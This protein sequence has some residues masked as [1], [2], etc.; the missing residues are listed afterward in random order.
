MEERLPSAAGVGPTPA[1]VENTNFGM[2]IAGLGLLRSTESNYLSR[3]FRQVE[4]EK[5]EEEE[6][7]RPYGE[8][9]DLTEELEGQILGTIE[10]PATTTRGFQQHADSHC[11]HDSFFMMFFESYATKPIVIGLLKE[12]F[13]SMKALGITNL[14]IEKPIVKLLA[15]RLKEIRASTL[16]LSTWAFLVTALQRYVLLS[17]L[18]LQE[19][20]IEVGS[21]APVVKS[22]MLNRRKS[23]RA[24]K[25]DALQ[26]LLKY[27]LYNEC[28]PGLGKRDI[29]VFMNSMA[30]F[31]KEVSGGAYTLEP[32]INEIRNPASVR[33]YYFSIQQHDEKRTRELLQNDYMISRI[34]MR[35]IPTEQLYD[36]IGP[37]H[38]ISLFQVGATWFLYDN[39]V[40]I[41][42]LAEA[43]STAVSAVGIRDMEI[44]ATRND[45]IY[46]IHLSD[47]ADFRVSQPRISENIEEGVEKP[48]RALTI[49]SASYR[50]VEVE[51]VG[52]ARRKHA[53]K[54]TRKARR[55]RNGFKK[56]KPSRRLREFL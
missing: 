53:H 49:R 21:G 44:L 35:Y 18:F 24:T 14:L 6:R 3:K 13:A 51:R 36:F 26:D 34:N 2:K 55:Q 4:R 38:I 8:S 46:R 22:R 7:N 5:A 25:F 16:P 23:I 54:N 41:Y 39:E 11:W 29:Q 33:G 30:D 37:A 1:A 31:V 50:L 52:G 15:S 42:P 28:Y 12:L 17:F 47:G 32:A 27:G 43:Y 9:I 40:G 48:F 20:H 45:F 56:A 10:T 19:P